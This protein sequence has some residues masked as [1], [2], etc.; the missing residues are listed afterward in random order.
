MDSSFYYVSKIFNHNFIL[1]KYAQGDTEF[2]F[3]NLPR[4]NPWKLS[5]PDGWPSES[6][7]RDFC[8]YKLHLFKLWV[9][10]SFLVCPVSWRRST[11]PPESHEGQWEGNQQR[12]WSHIQYRN[13][14]LPLG[15]SFSP[16]V[17][18]GCVLL[19]PEWH[20]DRNWRGSWAQ[21]LSSNGPWLLSVSDPLCSQQSL[22]WFV[23]QFLI[24]T[25]IIPMSRA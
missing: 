6:F 20:S 21:T 3:Y 1:E 14:L 12:L 16:R 19:C 18:L 24:D 15:E 5:D 10:L 23:S 13:Y 25:K 2:F 8:D 7:R 22:W 11:A 4:T 9:P 17:R